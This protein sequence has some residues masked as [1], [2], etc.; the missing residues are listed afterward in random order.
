MK[1]PSNVWE[2]WADGTYRLTTNSNLLHLVVWHEKS[3]W[4]YRVVQLGGVQLR[5]SKKPQ[6]SHDAARELCWK[7]AQKLLTST[8]KA[9]NAAPMKSPL[10]VTP[11]KA[12]RRE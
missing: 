4:F 5:I 8:L 3:G 11:Y 1:C 12:S 6:R 9:L 2:L 10:K 7:A